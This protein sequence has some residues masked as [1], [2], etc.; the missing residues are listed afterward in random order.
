LNTCGE[1]EKF[2][3]TENKGSATVRKTTCL[4][5]AVA[6][7]S[8]LVAT[9]IPAFA[10]NSGIDAANGNQIELGA[11]QVCGNALTVVGQVASALS[12]QATACRN[13]ASAGS[14]QGSSSDS[15]QGPSSG[16]PHAANSSTPSGGSGSPSAGSKLPTAPKPVSVVGHHAVTG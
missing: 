8:G 5:G 13:G 12:P 10:D 6:V 9:G 11:V 2:Q 16:N 15:P 4:V 14:P 3:E 1:S 7:G